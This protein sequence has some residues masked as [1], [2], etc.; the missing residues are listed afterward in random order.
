MVSGEVL[1]A[2]GTMAVLA[3]FMTYVLGWANNT[4]H[5]EVDPR[6]EKAEEILPGANCG[7]C[8]YVGCR[9]YAEAV[10]GGEA[11]NKCTV[12]GTGVAQELAGLLEHSDGIQRKGIVL[13]FLM[14]LKQICNHPSQWL[15]DNGYESAESGK[16]Q[17]LADICQEL[18]QRQQKALVF[19]QFREIADPLAGHLQGVF[20]RPGL[21]LHGQTPVGKRREMV[22]SFQQEDGPP[23]FVLSLKAGGTGLNLT[24][25]SH[26]I[27]VDRWW[28]PA[29]ENQATDRAFRIG[30]R[31]N[32]LVHKFV[33]RGTVEERIDALIAEKR[34]LADAVL[35]GGAEIRAPGERG[36]RA[37]GASR[38]A[39]ARAT[40][41]ERRGIR[42]RR[43]RLGGLRWPMGTEP[44]NA[45]SAGPESH[46]LAAASRARSEGLK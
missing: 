23:F 41:H 26:V 40:P 16:F 20:G 6:V 10:V 21:V 29:V 32:V 39:P 14:R 37:D 18:A 9:E 44:G 12:G 46:R 33:T 5:V 8:G 31:R 35:A 25:A 38:G 27:H 17:R 7:G 15:G 30:Q 22:A 4:F 13:A 42:A 11:V 2:G 43:R 34:Q 45:A 36:L 28:N 19:T 24:E 1:L 3:V